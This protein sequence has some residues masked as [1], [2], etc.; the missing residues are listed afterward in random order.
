MLEERGLTKLCICSKDSLAP[1]PV[2]HN[3]ILPTFLVTYLCSNSSWI[4]SECEFEFSLR[5]FVGWFI[6]S[7]W[8]DLKISPA[9]ITAH[10]ELNLFLYFRI[11]FR[12]FFLCRKDRIEETC[13]LVV[14]VLKIPVKKIDFF[15][16]SRNIKFHHETSTVDSYFWQ[17]RVFFRNLKI[18]WGQIQ[19]YCF[20]VLAFYSQRFLQREFRISLFIAPLIRKHHQHHQSSTFCNNLQNVDGNQTGEFGLFK[21]CWRGDVCHLENNGE[22]GKHFN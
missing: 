18:G 12:T 9:A 5:T 2:V 21:C 6:K 3:E 14:I 17:L 13:W 20:V 10:F 11:S 4:K 1:S 7:V 22:Q 16:L 19:N 8:L 15:W